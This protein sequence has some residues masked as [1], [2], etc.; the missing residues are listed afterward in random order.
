ME[1]VSL[2]KSCQLFQT[3][4]IHEFT[5]FFY[6]FLLFLFIHLSEYIVINRI[7]NQIVP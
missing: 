3:V 7:K 4:N 5:I 2:T 6:L 1:L